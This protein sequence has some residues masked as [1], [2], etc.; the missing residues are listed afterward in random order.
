LVF[1]WPYAG[2]PGPA[3]SNKQPIAWRNDNELRIDAVPAVIDI[4]LSGSSE[5]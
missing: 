2:A 4:E 5:R 1:Q 3:F